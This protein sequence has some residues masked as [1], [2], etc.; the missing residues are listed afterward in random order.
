MELEERKI[1]YWNLEDRNSLIVAESV[2]TLSSVV[3]WKIK[4]NVPNRLGNQTK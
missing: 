3:M 4:K 2:V 1:C